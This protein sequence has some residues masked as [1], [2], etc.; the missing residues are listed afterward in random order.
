M[1]KL[2]EKAEVQTMQI[3][4]QMIGDE[5]LVRGARN[6]CIMPK[7]G[8]PAI[9][10]AGAALKRAC[11]SRTRRALAKPTR[12]LFATSAGRNSRRTRRAPSMSAGSIAAAIRPAKRF[13]LT[14]SRCEA[15]KVA[16]RYQMELKHK[17][18]RRGGLVSSAARGKC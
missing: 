10:T 7:K 8:R 5:L 18:R 9:R 3:I 2:R 6:N 16:W 12:A 14:L 13:R 11:Q 17:H 4:G 15:P 1:S